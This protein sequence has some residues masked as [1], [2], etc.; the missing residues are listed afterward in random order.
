ML[1]VFLV[2]AFVIV[3]N[4]CATMS[5]ARNLPSGD[6]RNWITYRVEVGD[7]IVQFTIPPGLNKEFLDPPVPQSIDLHQPGLFDEAGLGPSVLSRHWNY[8]KNFYTHVDGTLEV[9]LSLKRSEGVLNGLDSLRQAIV[10]SSERH[11]QKRIADQRSSG[12]YIG[13]PNPPIRF[14]ELIVAG[15]PGLRVHF[16]LMLPD[17]EVALNDHYYLVIYINSSV[18]EPGWREDAKAAAAAIFNSIRIDPKP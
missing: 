2:V 16:K 6:T 14:E 18:T 10:K 15:R 1:R 13:P 3:M 8:Q 4:G 11:R 5:D 9:T 17:Y 7:Q 12:G